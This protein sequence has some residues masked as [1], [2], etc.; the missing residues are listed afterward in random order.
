MRRIIFLFILF[1]LLICQTSYAYNGN[2][3]YDGGVSSGHLVIHRDTYDYKEVV[4]LTGK[5]IIFQGKLEIT[6]RERNDSET[7]TYKY[8]LTHGEKDVL[9]RTFV[10]EN[11]IEKV[12]GQTLKTC[13]LKSRPMETIRIGDNTYSLD[14]LSN[15]DFSMGIVIDKRAFADYF[16]G[17]YNYKKI[18]ELRND[19]QKITVSTTGQVY[20][21]DQEWSSAETLELK[22]FITSEGSIDGQVNNWSGVCDL[23]ISS[24]M[25]KKLIYVDNKPQ[26][27]S[28]EGGYLQRQENNGVLNY[29]ANLPVFDSKG[30]ATDKIRIYE[31]D[32]SVQSFPEQERLIIPDLNK[33][34]G[35][36]CEESVLQLYSLGIYDSKDNPP[37]SFIPNK[38]MTRAEFSKSLALAGKLVEPEK[39]QNKNINP[40]LYR[41]EESEIDVIYDDVPARHPYFK[42]INAV[43][44]KNVMN[45]LEYGRFEPDSIITR[46]QA[47][48]TF[49][50]ALG[51]ESIAP[52]QNAVTYFEDNDEI[53][54]WARNSIK[55]ASYIGII[56]GDEYGNFNPNK[57]M[58]KAEASMMLNRLIHYMRYNIIKDYKN[59]VFIY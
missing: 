5:P 31:D 30:I 50:R 52:G 4:F 59:R 41:N 17:N 9:K 37:S 42:Y 26:E 7:V 21:Y 35:H 40:R 6:K 56:Q 14:P 54:S 3:G 1:I 46:A 23:K 11:K 24:S 43:S 32:I 18:Y 33:I 12:N 34:K 8:D 39:E 53:P 15:I 57:P 38:F 22:A 49:I 2:C 48:T 55:V 13:S 44:E 45:G 19:N 25:V 36:W 51:F 28:F 27:I 58:T 16:S 29:T 20:G 10:L 47:V